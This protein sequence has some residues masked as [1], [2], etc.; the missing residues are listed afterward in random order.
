MKKNCTNGHKK[1]FCGCWC[2]FFSPPPCQI[3]KFSQA[4][5][6][7]HSCYFSSVK[8]HIKSV[9]CHSTSPVNQCYQCQAMAIVVCVHVSLDQTS[10]GIP[11]L[12]ESLLAVSCGNAIF[13]WT[14]TAC[15][16]LD[17]DHPLCCQSL[18]LHQRFSHQ[19]FPQF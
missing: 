16:C 19:T 15:I 14:K 4:C 17:K 13:R 18:S 6:I 11:G 1:R 5:W 8:K 9:A 2:N 3:I 12:E 10:Q 7:G